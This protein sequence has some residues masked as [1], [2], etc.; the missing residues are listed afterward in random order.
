M[1][2]NRKQDDYEEMEDSFDEADAALGLS[3][4]SFF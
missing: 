2:I 3:I 1:N 4:L